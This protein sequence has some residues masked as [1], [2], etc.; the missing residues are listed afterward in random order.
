MNA[1][2]PGSIAI[3]GDAHG[4]VSA[5]VHVHQ[6]LW[7][8]TWPHQ[9]GVVPL[10]AH[11]RQERPA[12]QALDAAVAAGEGVVVC[13]V[14]A[15]LGG[16][17]KTQLAVALARRLWDCGELDLLVWVSATSRPAV[18]TAYAQAAADVVGVDD[19]DPE[20]AAVRFLAWLAATPRRWLIV[21]DDVTDANDLQGLW[22]AATGSGR[23][24]V[25]TR[26]MDSALAAGRHRIDV[27]VFTPAESMNYLAAKLAG[28]SIRLEQAADL[29][30]DL[31][32]LPLALAQA[33][34]YILDRTSMTCASYRRR[35]A[36]RRRQLVALAPRVLPDDYPYPVAV[37][38]SL[39]IDRADTFAPEG[40]ARPV[41]ELAALLN[42]NGIPTEVF[43]T[44]AVLTHLGAR[45]GGPIAADDVTDALD[46]LARLSLATTDPE[47]GTVRVHGLLQRAVREATPS[48]HAAQ[49]AVTAADAL[50]SIWPDIE[51]GRD[52]AQA[53]RA[54]TTA[55]H[56]HSDPLLWNAV[57]GVHPVLF[58]AGRSLGRTGQLAAAIAYFHTL[59][60][61][62]THHLGPDHPGTLTTRNNLAYWRGEA[63]DPG[64]AAAA[65][66]DLLTDCLRVLGPDHPDTLA[67]RSNIARWRGEAGDPGGAAAAS[68]DLLTDCLRVLGPDHPDTL[69]TRSNIASWRGE[70]GDPGGAAAAFEELLT[71]RLRVLG[72][73]HPDTLNTRSN[74]ASWR[75]EAGDPG[76]AAAA[77]E[78]LLTD[79]LRMLGPDHPDTLIIRNNIAH[80]LGQAGDPTGAVT[81]Y[82]EL[83]T[84][85]LRVLGPDHP[86]A[87]TTR[88]N[89]A[90][91]LG[92][93][94]DPTGAVTAYRELLTDQLRVLGPD[95]PDTLNTR[96]NIARWR[97]EAG[98]PTGAAA[99]SRDLLTDCLR[100]LGPDHPNTL[101]ARNNIAYC[102]G[103]AGDLTGAAAAFEE[104]LTD[105]LRV[106][107]PDHPG[108][109]ITRNNVAHCLGEAGDPAGAAAALDELLA[110]CLRV[111]GPNHLN[112]VTVHGNLARWRGRGRS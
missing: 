109:L 87:L 15:G 93:A 19:T 26:S 106:L 75:S 22:P 9:V 97:S 36:D 96:S 108:T 41:L 23:T 24:V 91:C 67:T 86:R 90:Y 8:V 37:T 45:T 65:F 68:K 40:L 112:T 69:A 44:P 95:H 104:L 79:F 78:E 102:L 6:P 99:A 25:T 48:A 33:A 60:I 17:G 89:I 76:G 55:L 12:D 61:T 47:T 58:A 1:S 27:G 81:A 70:A 105:Q 4:P 73:D 18:V 100:V 35:L 13:Q 57:R 11:C 64:G 16:V 54:N 80:C 7:Q 85:Q 74:I 42:P 5:T 39:S 46:N 98:D 52:H 20:Q 31:G 32:H 21:L 3:G 43:T 88:N 14:A 111:L 101:I 50:R 38:W 82:R 56:T 94:G 29:A 59:N 77:F 107:G 34:A 30:D 63:G 83:L 71:D 72:P 10:L 51:R 110:D 49:L 53:L 92:Q 66:E 2:A 103:Q 62:A 84:D 28:D